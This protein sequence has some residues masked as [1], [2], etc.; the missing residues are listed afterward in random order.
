MLV[1]DLLM[2]QAELLKCSYMCQ[3]KELEMW[4]LGNKPKGWILQNWVGIYL[5]RH[6]DEGFKIYRIFSNLI[7]TI[8]TVSEGYKAD[9]D[10]NCVRTRFAVE[11]WILEKW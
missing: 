9:A 8:F 5:V 11:S 10:Y 3:I 1:D 7:R 2:E 4:K 6:R